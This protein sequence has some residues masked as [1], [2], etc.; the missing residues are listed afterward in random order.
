M[1]KI[2]RHISEECSGE[3]NGW[4]PEALKAVLGRSGYRMLLLF[5]PVLKL[6]VPEFRSRPCYWQTLFMFNS[7]SPD[8]QEKCLK[9]PWGH[10]WLTIDG[11]R[12][13]RLHP[14]LEMSRLNGRMEHIG[15]AGKYEYWAMVPVTELQNPNR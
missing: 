6:F 8:K 11:K 10:A 7:L 2:E 1:F 15:S 14:R 4:Q 12:L 13:G 3:Q 9:E 5:F